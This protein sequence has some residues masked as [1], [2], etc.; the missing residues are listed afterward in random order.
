MDAVL[1]SATASASNNNEVMA[2]SI[3][4]IPGAS[5][6]RD[7]DDS[8]EVSPTKKLLN[9]KVNRVHQYVKSKLL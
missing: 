8:E 7:A 6:L 5:G 3:K 2:S 4:E 1:A 9:A